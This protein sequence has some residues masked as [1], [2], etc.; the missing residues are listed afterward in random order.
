MVTGFNVTARHLCQVSEKSHSCRLELHKL[1]CDK[2]SIAEREAILKTIRAQSQVLGWLLI[3][4][5]MFSSLLFTCLARCRSPV[6]YMQ[7]K[8]WRDY[9]KEENCLFDQYSSL[10]AKKLAERNMK[11]FFEMT[12]PEP[13]SIPPRQAWEKISKFYRFETMDKYYS[14]VHKYVE[15]C[16]NPKE[17]VR[18]YSTRS[19]DADLSNP[20]ALAFV[21]EGML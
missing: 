8:F 7:L 16:E 9:A 2:T 5:I 10:Y 6:S 17:P 12:T 13:Q 3:A 4:S 11:S 15:T 20:A 21:D 19:G 14:T 18:T 1:P